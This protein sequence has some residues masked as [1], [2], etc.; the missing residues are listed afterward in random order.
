[1]QVRKRAEFFHGERSAFGS[2][3]VTER[4]RD[5]VKT[6][7]RSSAALRVAVRLRVG[8]LLAA[9]AHWLARTAFQLARERLISVA[10]A[11]ALLRMAAQV[12]RQSIRLRQRE[13]FR[14]DRW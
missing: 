8:G 5:I 1:M 14:T 6:R 10:Q 12:N 9:G 7:G 2:R 4:R 13:R 3:L 11:K